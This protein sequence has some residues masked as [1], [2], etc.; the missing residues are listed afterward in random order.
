M[1]MEVENVHFGGV[2]RKN[3]E[4]MHEM[5]KWLR[6]IR[7]GIRGGQGALIGDWNAHHSL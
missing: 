4:D 3:E 6:G 7:R 2:Y 5:G 1:Y